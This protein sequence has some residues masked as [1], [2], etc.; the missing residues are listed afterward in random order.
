MKENTKNVLLGVLIVGLVAM[1]VAYAA[2][3]TTLRISGTASVPAVS[4]NVRFENW[5]KADGSDGLAS[6]VQGQANTGSATAV[7]SLTQQASASNSTYVSGIHVDLLQPG[8]NIKYEFDI[9]NRG[10]IDAKLS[11]SPT[12][13]LTGSNDSTVGT[14]INNN[15]VTY[16]VSCPNQAELAKNGG[17]T[18]CTLTVKYNEN[19]V[20]QNQ[21][22]AGSDQ[23]Y[24]QAAM[25]LELGASWVYVQ[26]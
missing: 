9:V 15:V 25:N 8:D 10:T 18:H 17:T 19:I 23:T 22:Q 26:K 13:T 12:I 20:N 4:W 7:A 2:L 21:N 14:A 3:S 5:T 6:L 1:T 24:S 16:N 11:G